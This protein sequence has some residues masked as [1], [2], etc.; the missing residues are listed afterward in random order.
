MDCAECEAFIATVNDN[1]AMRQ[2]VVGEWTARYKAKN[3]NRSDLKVSDINCRGCLSDRP[4]FLYCEQCKIRK[5]GLARGL[6]NCQNCPE[7]KCEDLIEK[8]SHFWKK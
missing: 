7:Y 1:D 5:C 4:I 8:Q 2:K 3:Y 6:K